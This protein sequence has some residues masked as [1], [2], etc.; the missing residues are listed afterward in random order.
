MG[1]HLSPSLLRMIRPS[2]SDTSDKSSTDRHFVTWTD[3]VCFSYPKLLKYFT[4]MY[5]LGK[6]FL[7]LFENA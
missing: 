5:S 2:P 3:Q 1:P 7:Q 4:Y 6:L